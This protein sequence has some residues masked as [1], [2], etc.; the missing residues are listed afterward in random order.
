[1]IP[2]QGTK[3]REVK[4]D[5]LDYMGNQYRW[6]LKK[7]SDGDYRINCHGYAYSN[8]QCKHLKDDIEWVAD[9]GNWTQVIT[10]IN[11]GVKRVTSIKSRK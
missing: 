6:T 11:S 10:M 8:F 3:P 7:D 9:E 2:K 5:L 1:M 4:I